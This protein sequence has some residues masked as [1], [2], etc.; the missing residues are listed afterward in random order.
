M[1]RVAFIKNGKVINVIIIDDVNKI[2]DFIVIGVDEQGNLVKKS[3]CEIFVET[4]VGSVGDFYENGVGFYR[5]HET[6][7][8]G[9]EQVAN[10]NDIEEL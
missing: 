5:L 2:P 4:K 7:I 1:N 10:Q 9:I 8:N 6:D 3:E